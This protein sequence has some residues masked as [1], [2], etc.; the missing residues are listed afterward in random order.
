MGDGCVGVG[1]GECQINN[2]YANISN[3]KYVLNSKI[4]HLSRG[5]GDLEEGRRGNW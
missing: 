5:V 2:E 3:D 4:P 1:C